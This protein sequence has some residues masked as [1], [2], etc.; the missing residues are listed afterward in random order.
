[1]ATTEKGS[2]T[3]AERIA[4]AVEGV[5]G[6]LA[7]V[8]I[9]SSNSS[10]LSV[11]LNADGLTGFAFGDGVGDASIVANATDVDGQALPAGMADITVTD[12]LA[13]RAKEIA[14][15]LGTPEPRVGVLSVRGR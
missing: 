7:N 13:P 11:V 4:F 8:K 2:I 6:E 14:V 5:G 3:K 10:V 15:K 1:M 9:D 12:V